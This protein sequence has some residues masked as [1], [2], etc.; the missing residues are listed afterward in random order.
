[1]AWR[2]GVAGEAAPLAARRA[3]SP[4]KSRRPNLAQLDVENLDA[5]NLDE[6][7]GDTPGSR[8]ALGDVTPSHN[9]KV[10]RLPFQ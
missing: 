6:R 4:A 10:P 9:A 1:M 8:R 2:D 7:A 3:G 5:P